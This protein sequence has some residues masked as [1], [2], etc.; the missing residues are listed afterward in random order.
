[1]R[2]PV[3]KYLKRLSLALVILAL[4]TEAFARWAM[5]LCDPPLFV[6][7]P[8][9]EYMLQPN[10]NCW[11]LGSRIS[12]NRYSMRS[13]DFDPQKKP[14]EFRI[15][16]VGDSILYGGSV[17][18]QKLLATHLLQGRMH[19]ESIHRQT[20]VCNAA[21]GGWGPANQ[22]A[23]LNRFGTFDADVAI[24]VTSS[25]DLDDVPTFNSI[26]GI[27]P[28]FL[29]KK[30]MFA[31]SQIILRYI[32]RA[33]ALAEN[34]P[35]LTAPPPTTQPVDLDPRVAGSLTSLLRKLHEGNRPVYYFVHRRSYEVGKP[36]PLGVQHMMDLAAGEG[37]TVI[38]L[39]SA[40]QTALSRGVPV[41]RDDIHLTQDGQ[42]TLGNAI[43]DR[44]LQD[45]GKTAGKK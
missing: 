22:V 8:Q 26:V 9:I 30:P 10:Q 38:D 44:L 15:L 31:M 33:I 5:G 16:A 6:A 1:M 43:A 7:D 36:P 32:P 34:R 20:L 35:V 42:I 39:D 23:Y 19:D 3:R 18:D 2:I 24:I 4:L 21:L 17:V 27:Q 12:V 13:D 37:A 14:G 45:Y 25:D 28:D 29:D 41:Y 40:I 11:I